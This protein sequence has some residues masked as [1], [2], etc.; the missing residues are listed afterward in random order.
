MDP[1]GRRMAAMNVVERGVA[2]C[3]RCV[4]VA[5]YSFT[6]CES[7]YVRYEIRCPRCS[8]V[9]IEVTCTGP[10]VF[11][12][13]VERYEY[14]RP[15]RDGEALTRAVEE[16]RQRWNTLMGAGVRVIR[17]TLDQ[18]RASRVTRHRNDEVDPRN[19]GQLPP[20][21]AQRALEEARHVHL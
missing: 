13:D 12:T 16:L 20:Q 9:Y 6:E 18:I 10:T 1:G 14:S 8:E 2:R 11:S 15:Q 17:Q 5:E 19:L 4:A 21:F 7:D 3:P